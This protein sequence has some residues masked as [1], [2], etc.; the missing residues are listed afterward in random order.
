[1]AR[2]EISDLKEDV[3]LSEEEI[4]HVKGGGRTIGTFGKKTGTGYTE[5]EWTYITVDP[6]TGD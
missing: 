6:K 1:M 2:I 3:V 4:K 5:V